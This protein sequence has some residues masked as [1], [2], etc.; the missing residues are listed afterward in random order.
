MQDD[1]KE[2]I[3]N[4]TDIKKMITKYNKILSTMELKE[5]LK[6]KLNNNI[7]RIVENKVKNS[8]TTSKI[9]EE[10]INI[11]CIILTMKE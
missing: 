10:Y 5:I 4:N 6:L 8:K 9:V 1:L 7:D 2:D 3:N 11:T